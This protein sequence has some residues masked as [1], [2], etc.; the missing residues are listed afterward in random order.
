MKLL[1]ERRYG[2]ARG[3]EGDNVTDGN[4]DPEKGINRY[5]NV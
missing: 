4:Q 1:L 5:N 3:K 2:T